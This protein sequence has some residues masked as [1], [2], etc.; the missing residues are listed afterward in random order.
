[1][2]RLLMSLSMRIQAR[3]GLR[4][5][6]RLDE[7]PLSC[8]SHHSVGVNEVED[9]RDWT[10]QETTPDQQR[11]ED[12]LA[13]GGKTTGRAVLHV[14]IGNSSLARRFHRS[15]GIIDGITIQERE[16][17]KADCLQLSNYRPML[18]SKYHWDLCSILNG[19]YDF[20]V[21]NNPTTFCCCRTHLASMLA[22]YSALLMPGGVILS[23]TVGLYWASEPN[24]AR[25]RVTWDEWQSIGR[26]YGLE[27]VRYTEFVV[28][29][30]RGTP[31]QSAIHTVRCVGQLLRGS[32]VNSRA[33]R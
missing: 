32:R 4:T 19:A 22:N 14:G 3:A 23:D 26:A 20:I 11:I 27:G 28:G 10:D 16:V 2:K 25:W 12:V 29:L 7:M 21:D 31:L 6:T 9:W 30:R 8:D 1:M 24:D 5:N 18:L 15:A 33:D 17:E 13:E